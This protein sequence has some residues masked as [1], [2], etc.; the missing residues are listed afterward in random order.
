MSDPGAGHSG[1]LCLF[2]WRLVSAIESTTT[3]AVVAVVSA[4]ATAVESATAAT[5]TEATTTTTTI[6][7]ALLVLA[8]RFWTAFVNHYVTAINRTT[9]QG[10]DRS[11]RLVVVSHF[12]KSEAFAAGGEFVSNDFSN[13]YFTILGEE[14]SQVLVFQVPAKVSN[15]NVHLEM[16]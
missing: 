13:S 4:T 3:V 12:N 10:S 16:F 8:F 2:E 7:G 5:A 9:V 15:I 6:E 14:V 1:C 11:L